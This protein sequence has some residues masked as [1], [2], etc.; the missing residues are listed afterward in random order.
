VPLISVVIATYNRAEY[1]P[2][3]LR[4][5]FAQT[6]RDLEV[7][8]IDDG[9]TDSTQQVLADF[10]DRITYR[11]QSN[12]ERGAAR[13]HGLAI[14]SGRYVAFLDSDDLWLPNKLEA[15]LARLEANP[16][17]GLAYSRAAY[18]GEDGRYLGPMRGVA[19]EGDVLP[20]LVRVGNI[21]PFGAHLLHRE[22]FEAVGGF[23][24][25]RS[26]AG[27]EDWE[28][29]VRFAFRYPFVHAPNLGL[30]YR[31]HKGGTVA[32]PHHMKDAMWRAYELI[33][34]NEDLLG[35]IEPYRLETECYL[36]QLMASLFHGSGNRRAALSELGAVVRKRPRLCIS[37]GFVGTAGRVLLGRR[38]TG[39]L[40]SLRSARRHIAPPFPVDGLLSPS[41]AAAR[42][43]GSSHQT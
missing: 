1:L 39:R 28:A 30:F 32:N 17:S 11:Y 3:T 31:I 2:G 4:S 14:A 38:V 6:V 16:S 8:V 22:R 20:A 23:R 27:S 42:A 40:A 43:A 24:E 12:K 35:R 9:S 18:I 21:V 10:G 33:Y 34:G 36:H 41:V 15:E 37:G 26:L 25:D 5:V 13:N 7:I 29:W 19:V